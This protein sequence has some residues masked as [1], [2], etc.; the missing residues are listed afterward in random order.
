MTCLSAKREE[1][2]KIF[3]TTDVNMAGIY[4][5]RLMVNGEFKTIIVDDY[6]PVDINSGYPAFSSTRSGNAWV[7]LLEKAWAKLNGSYEAIVAGR[8]IDVFSFL[9]PFPVEYCDIGNT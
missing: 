3:I 6:V 8:C 5:M 2:E 7:L 1:L 9:T 4:A